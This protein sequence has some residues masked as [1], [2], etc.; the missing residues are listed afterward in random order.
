MPL[1]EPAPRRALVIKLGHIG[2]VLVASPVITA[3]KQAWPDMSVDM[4]VN[5]GTEAMVAHNPLIDSVLVLKREHV[6]R[7]A[8]LAWQAGFL[9]ALRSTGY[10]LALELAEGDRGAF[11]AWISGARS[12]VGFRSKKPRLRSRA[13][14]HLAPRWDDQ[15]HMVES[16][17][18]QVE[19]LGIAPQDTALKFEPGGQARAQARDLLAGA[20]IGQG[21]YALVHPTSRWMFKSWTPQ[22]NAGLIAHLAKQGLKVVLTSGPDAKEL[23]LVERIRALT[24]PDAISLDLAG[25]LDLYVLGGLI[26]EARLFAGADSAPMHMA[27]ALQVPVLT[28][29]G[30]SG[31]AMWGP[32]QVEAEVLAGDCPEHPCGRDGCDGS[33]V[34]RCLEEMPLARVSAAADRLLQRTARA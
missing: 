20:G 25:K 27:A 10:D 6:S 14:T 3:L 4:L 17:L 31:E 33:K 11:L 8:E 13:Y 12:R 19:L 22:G 26:A 2:D 29:F 15:H 21:E 1:L 24:P 7:L 9:A 28:M 32:W 5:Q 23:E 16:F 18:R 30:P 34:S